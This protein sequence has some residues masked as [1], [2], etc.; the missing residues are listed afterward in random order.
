MPESRRAG[1]AGAPCAAR[2][3]ELS[4]CLLSKGGHFQPCARSHHQHF[5]RRSIQHIVGATVCVEQRGNFIFEDQRQN[6][7]LLVLG[8][9]ELFYEARVHL[10]NIGWSHNPVLICVRCGAAAHIQRK[11][12]NRIIFAETT[13]LPSAGGSGFHYEEREAR[14]IRAAG[15]EQCPQNF[16]LCGSVMNAGNRLNQ[17]ALTRPALTVAGRACFG[18][19]GCGCRQFRQYAFDQFR[20]QFWKMMLENLCHRTLD[21]LL[22]FIAVRHAQRTIP[23]LLPPLSTA[24]APK[25]IFLT[26]DYTALVA[27]AL[28][29]FGTCSSA[30]E[31]AFQT[32]PQTSRLATSKPLGKG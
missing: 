24:P 3:L 13:A 28:E 9:T 26:A 23:D 22:E 11:I 17:T 16:F 4:L 20:L 25:T 30:S 2:R 10:R 14:T 21:D 8:P 27:M 31:L 12:F 6:Q 29:Y 1:P 15:I 19:N 18:R 5:K 7:D 32:L